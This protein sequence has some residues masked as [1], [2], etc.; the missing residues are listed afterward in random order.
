MISSISSST[1]TLAFQSMSG[2]ASRPAPPDAQEMFNRI[3][4]D[5]DGKVS[6]AEMQAMSED[7]A[8]KGPG[9]GESADGRQPPTAEEMLAELDGDGDGVVSFAEFEARRPPEPPQGPPPELATASA[10]DLASLFDTESEENDGTLLAL[11][12]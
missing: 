10:T 12:A 8:A 5:G 9:R 2:A 4:T 7:M 6:L 3:D 11:L 1:S